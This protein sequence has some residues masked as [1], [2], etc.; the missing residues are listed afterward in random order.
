MHTI[1]IAG[2][3]QVG[4][5]TLANIIAEEVFAQG[6]TPVLL[7]FAGPIKQEAKEKGYDKETHPE[8]YREYCQTMGKQMREMDSDYWVNL[9]GKAIEKEMDKELESL[10]EG[11]KYWERCVI[12]D[13][14]RYPN[15]IV[16][17]QDIDAT[18]IF[19]SSGGR[20]LENHEWR[21]HESEEF[22]N[23]VENFRDEYN[24]LFTHIFLNDKDIESLREK[25]KKMIPMWCKISLDDEC[26][27]V[28]CRLKRDG[29]SAEIERAMEQLIDLLDLPPFEDWMD[30]ED[31]ETK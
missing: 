10:D 20:K 12:I 30:E 31:E 17:G 24:E 28:R 7:S 21:Q 19:L 9:M 25:V 5:T 8:K 14:C 13:D 6:M 11:K 3:A 4:K 18:L 1:M 15:E 22:A 27:C 26:Q 23:E 2:K 16:L 29:K